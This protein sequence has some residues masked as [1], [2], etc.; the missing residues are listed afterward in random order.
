MREKRRRKGSEGGEGGEGGKSE[1]EREE[2]REGRRE[3][4]GGREVGEAKE[5]GTD[6]SWARTHLL[7]SLDFCLALWRFQSLRV[8]SSEPVSTI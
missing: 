1:G 2:G 8:Q 4:K 5:R 6:N 7:L 3:S